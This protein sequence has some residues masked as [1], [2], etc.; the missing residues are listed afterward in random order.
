MIPIAELQKKFPTNPPPS[1]RW[2]SSK[3]KQHGLG[4]QYGKFFLVREDFIERYSEKISCRVTEKSERKTGQSHTP[5]GGGSRSG[6]RT[7]RSNTDP[8]SAALE[9]ARSPTSESAPSKSNE[10]TTSA[11]ISRLPARQK[12]MIR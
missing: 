12:A 1:S 2:I 3:A 5:T 10:T 6:K 4:A 9:L 11:S 8:L 7:A